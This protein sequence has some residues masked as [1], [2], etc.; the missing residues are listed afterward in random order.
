M[1]KK[2]R[3]LLMCLFCFVLMGCSYF[4]P[5]SFV[6]SR[7]N[8]YLNAKSIPPLRMPDGLSSASFHNNYPVP[9]NHYPTINKSV[10]L[11]PPGLE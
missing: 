7:D 3:Y 8:H 11:I 1:T 10:S 4:S 5:S 9:Q 2:S 6:E